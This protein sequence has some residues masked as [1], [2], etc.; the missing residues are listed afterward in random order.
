MLSESSRRRGSGRT[1]SRCHTRG[2]FLVSD[3]TEAPCQLPPALMPKRLLLAPRRVGGLRRA[4]AGFERRLRD[5]RARIDP[6]LATRRLCLR[7]DLLDELA[8]SLSSLTGSAFCGRGTASSS[9]RL[10]LR[11]VAQLADQHVGEPEALALRIS[12]A[13]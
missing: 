10:H 2:V 12:M 9:R 11:A 6:E 4:P 7:Q 8:A 5:D 3:A 1:S 13:S